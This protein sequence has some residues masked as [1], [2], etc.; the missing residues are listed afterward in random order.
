[1][2]SLDATLPAVRRNQICCLLTMLGISGCAAPA[3]QPTARPSLAPATQPAAFARQVAMYLTR[4]LTDM[5]LPEIGQN[6]G[7]RDHSTVIHAYDTIA[8]KI[9]TD[10]VLSQELKEIQELAKQI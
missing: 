9:Q 10:L 1:M 3:W 6:F 8:A 5:S 4:E 2:A 7:G